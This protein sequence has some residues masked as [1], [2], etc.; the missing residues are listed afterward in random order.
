MKAHSKGQGAQMS[1]TV[2]GKKS[3]VDKVLQNVEIALLYLENEPRLPNEEKR[4]L[5][6]SIDQ[7]FELALSNRSNRSPAYILIAKHAMDSEIQHNRIAALV[8]K[9][10]A[11]IESAG[12]EEQHYLPTLIHILANDSRN[13][14]KAHWVRN[15]NKIA[16]TVFRL[17]RRLQTLTKPSAADAM[18]CVFLLHVVQ[19]F[20]SSDLR[21]TWTPHVQALCDLLTH[22]LFHSAIS[23][24]APQQDLL[25]VLYGLVMSLDSAE[26]W[27]AAWESMANEVRALLL[28]ASVPLPC[29]KGATSTMQ[30]QNKDKHIEGIALA[31]FYRQ[32]LD[33][34]C[35]L[36][37]HLLRCGSSHGA[38]SLPIKKF[39]EVYSELMECSGARGVSIEGAA[40]MVLPQCQVSLLAVL[41]CL[42]HT[43]STSA[44]SSSLQRYGYSILSPLFR[45]LHGQKAHKPSAVLLDS[46]LEVLCTASVL[47][48]HTLAD[49]I[50]QYEG[51]GLHLLLGIFVE[52]VKRITVNPLLLS[53]LGK[54]KSSASSTSATTSDGTNASKNAST[55]LVFELITCLLSNCSMYLSVQMRQQ[56]EQSIYAGLLCIEKG[57]CFAP[58]A[59]H[60]KE[61]LRQQHDLL[62]AF[63]KLARC[64]S[65]ASNSNQIFSKNLMLL[66]RVCQPL[67]RIHDTYNQHAL[68]QLAQ[69]ICLSIAHILQPTHVVIPA[70]PAANM[71]QKHI[72]D[73]LQAAAEQEASLLVE[74]QAESTVVAT[75]GGEV[76]VQ[77]KSIAVAAAV[78]EKAVLQAIAFTSDGK[79]SKKSSSKDKA[80][81]APA[82]PKVVKEA[83]VKAAAVKGAA[84]EDDDDDLPDMDDT[85]A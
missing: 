30:L 12:F 80:T 11:L 8:D 16:Q 53:D 22:F 24:T 10:S 5:A 34:V 60:P 82:P 73:S 2:T 35:K 42:L 31:V 56:V 38:L 66:H 1:G 61:P 65:M 40:L 84:D 14:L 69:E 33:K 67:L 49:L 64:E 32:T 74:Q 62:Y 58:F 78:D 81:K 39:L 50:G 44:C 17:L 59:H 75:Y 25:A 57:V 3:S 13:E 51:T 63:L 47:F 19:A 76:V 55:L 28:L 15:M 29:C 27:A 85:L 9:V 72:S 6:T 21:S 48:P 26:R 70:Y 23:F 45:T 77:E 83:P 41:Q 20:L 4:H 79:S 71:V 54:R 7:A 52:E 18:Q 37:Q 43:Y 68:G 46:L 36:L